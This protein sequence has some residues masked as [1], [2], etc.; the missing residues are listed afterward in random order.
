MEILASFIFGVEW[1]VVFM[2]GDFQDLIKKCVQ[3]QKLNMYVWTEVVFL[4]DETRAELNAG[5]LNR[6]N[7]F[8]MV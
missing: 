4:C 5:K 6:Q 8:F 2:M 3:F 1:H 7:C